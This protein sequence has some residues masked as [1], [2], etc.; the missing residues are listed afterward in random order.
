MPSVT[1]TYGTT[2]IVLVGSS[3]AGLVQTIASQ[4]RQLP[5][6]RDPAASRFT[7][8]VGDP[9]AADLSVARLGAAA[10]RPSCARPD[11]LEPRAEATVR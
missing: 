4:S 7:V 11:R 9:V 1:R 8:W 10:L 3:A 2:R 5:L 6:R